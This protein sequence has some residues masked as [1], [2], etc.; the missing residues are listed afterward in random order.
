MSDGQ[1][2]PLPSEASKPHEMASEPGRFLGPGMSLGGTRLLL[3]WRPA[4]R[5]HEPSLGSR[6][7]HVNA[8]PDTAAGSDPGGERED[9][10]RRKREGQSTVAGRAGGLS[11]SSC[12]VLAYRGR[13]GAKGRGRPGLCEM[14][15]RKGGTSCR[16]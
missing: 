11:R 1:V 9:P 13:G 15:N 7:E 6:T 16:S 4:Y 10:K 14:G 12:E 2:W 3:R 8:W 5:Q